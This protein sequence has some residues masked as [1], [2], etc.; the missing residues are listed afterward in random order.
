MS[1][2][3]RRYAD[4]AA[5]YQ[6]AEPF[7]VAHEAEHCLMLGICD[8]LLHNAQRL[9]SEPYLATVEHA[10]EMVAA[11]LRTPPHNIVLSLIADGHSVEEMVALVAADAHTVYETMP[12]VLAP[13]AISRAFCDEWQRLTRQSYSLALSERI[14]RLDR[15]IPVSG[16]P[17]AMRRAEEADR[18]L[19]ERW[20]AE[21]AREA[22]VGEHIDPPRWVDEQLATQEDLRGLFVWVDGNG[23]PVTMV[24]YQ[25]RTPHGMR[26]G[27]VYTPPA[28]RR[29]GYASACTAAVSQHLLDSGRQ[30]CFLFTDLANPTSN[31]IYQEIGYRPVIDVE[32]YAFGAS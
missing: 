9:E 3:L 23:E 19:L 18:A 22:L 2:K 20:I 28:H 4:T 21:F 8:A 31:H 32:M 30:F 7:L 12:G 11:T 14:Y 5:F 10:G 17:G 29:K 16:V 13:S 15:V 1:L 24:G 25:G 26:I 6:R 27:P